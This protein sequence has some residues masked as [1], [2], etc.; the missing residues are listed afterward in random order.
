MRLLQRS[1][2][3]EFSHTR[4]YVGHDTIPPYA[5]LSHTWGSDY[6]EVTFE[7]I[8][9][10]TG[11]SKLG[12]AKLRFCGG[13]AKRDGLQ[14]FWVDTC[15]IDKSS[16]TELSEAINSMFR[17]YQGASRCYVYLSDIPTSPN[18][19]IL[20]TDFI[21]SRWF[22]RGWTLQ[23]LL[24]PKQVDF[25]SAEGN[26]LGD[27]TSLLHPIHSITR[28]S[29]Q[30]LQGGSL[31]AFTVEERMSWAEGRETRREEDAA[32]S[33]LGIFDI[34]I[35]LIYGE[36]RKRATVRL[37]KAINEAIE[38]EPS[39]LS[40]ILSSE[41]LRRNHEP[42]STVSS[43]VESASTVPP[44]TASHLNG[45]GVLKDR[46][47]DVA[48]MWPGEIV[49]SGISGVYLRQRDMISDA[50][51]HGGWDEVMEQLEVATSAYGENWVNVV[52]ISEQT[53]NSEDGMHT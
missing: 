38:D 34:Y 5:I 1:N 46:L 13:Q 2:D 42:T 32:Y 23:E 9:N 6:E 51:Y 53:S 20:L 40:S 10:G 52:R 24:A 25:F 50:A 17:W 36:G 37:L 16:S 45:D 26:W 33:L 30:A 29:V 21:R 12:Y 14:Y 28:I 31:S 49:R 27:K 47:I 48:P 7:D 43:N 8:R 18:Q 19:P 41:G 11:G 15:C 44:S 39:A 4:E 22:T 3:T 35:P